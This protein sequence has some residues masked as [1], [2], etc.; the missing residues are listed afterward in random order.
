[1]VW[2]VEQP[3]A[4]TQKLVLVL[5][6]N[7]HNHD[8]GRCD[9]SLARIA[10]DAGLGRDCII[11]AVKALAEKGFITTHRRQRFNGS[12]TSNC[13]TLNM[14]GVGGV[15]VLNDYP[16]R[17]KPLLEPGIEPGI[18]TKDMCQPPVATS[19]GSL[20]PQKPETNSERR[21]KI[22]TV[23]RLHIFPYYLDLIRPQS[24]GLYTLSPHRLR[25]AV[26][27]Y[28]ECLDKVDGDWGK[29]RELMECVISTMAASDF[30]M[31]RL[32]D[33]GFKKYDD[34]DLLFRSS[35]ML[36]KWFQRA[37]DLEHQGGIRNDAQ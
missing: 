14:A 26:G 27:R 24:N 25:M 7:R 3:V 1:M 9:P 20:F 35:D 13:Y 34:W 19:N 11:E 32:R 22:E 5:L 21:R 36:E 8:T 15:V 23:I 33:N 31:G 10:K 16:S 4:G 6:G 37:M 30:H 17:L 2:A 28:E 18:K 29:A 12:F